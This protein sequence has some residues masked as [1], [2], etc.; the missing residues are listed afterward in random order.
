[1][2]VFVGN[3]EYKN[4]FTKLCFIEWVISRGK[5]SSAETN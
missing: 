3:N 1:M 2:V 4:R 5:P